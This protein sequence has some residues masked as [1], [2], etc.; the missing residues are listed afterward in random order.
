M[1]RPY[2]WLSH[3]ERGVILDL[4]AEGKPLA[5]IA[6]ATKRPPGTIGTVLHAA[7]QNG[8]R[9][10]AYRVR[11]CGARRAEQRA[12]PAGPAPTTHHTGA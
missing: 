10:A 6:A 3:Q 8:D 1:P 7:R 2:R 9:R 4:W 12:L 11:S 5:D